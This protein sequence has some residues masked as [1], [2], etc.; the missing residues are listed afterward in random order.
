MSAHSRFFADLHHCKPD[1]LSGLKQQPS[2]SIVHRRHSGME[3]RHNDHFQSVDAWSCLLSL[4]MSALY[5]IHLDVVALL[6]ISKEDESELTWIGLVGMHDP[7]RK[8]VRGA[9]E[10]CKAAG[11]RLIVVTGDNKATA[12]AICSQVRN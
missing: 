8:E 3:P 12:T 5:F 7:P 4:C 11:I 6:Q 1:E 9:I 10:L 2:Q